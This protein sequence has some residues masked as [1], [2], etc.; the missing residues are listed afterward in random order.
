MAK[1]TFT[2]LAKAKNAKGVT[3]ALAHA[4]NMWGKDLGHG[5]WKLAVN[6]SHGRDVKTWRYVKIGMSEAEAAELFRK[7]VAQ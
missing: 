6:Y 2:I 5:V 4:T 7:K 3:F 1:D